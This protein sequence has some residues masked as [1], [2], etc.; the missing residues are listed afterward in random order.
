[1]D[2]KYLWPTMHKDALQ[3]YQACDKCQRMG[4]VTT[5]ASGVQP[6]QRHGKVRVKNEPMSHIHIP[7]SVEKSNHTLPNGLPFWEL[8][9]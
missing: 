5:L 7:K 4:N 1:M 6:K 9:S 3:F 2:A 8:K